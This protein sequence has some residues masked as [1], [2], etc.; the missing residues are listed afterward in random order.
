[1]SQGL[2]RYRRRD[3]AHMWKRGYEI[4]F[5]REALCRLSLPWT[6]AGRYRPRGRKGTRRLAVRRAEGSTRLRH[7]STGTGSTRTRESRVRDDHRGHHALRG[8][9]GDGRPS[10]PHW[11]RETIEVKVNAAR[12]SPGD[13]AKPGC[14]KPSGR[15]AAPRRG[16]SGDAGVR[17]RRRRFRA[18]PG[19]QGDPGTYPEAR[20]IA[21]TSRRAH[22]DWCGVTRWVPLWALSICPAGRL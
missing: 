17:T 9:R 3:G 18:R 14:W 20:Q 16:T 21:V 7:G 8:D 13:P 15:R 11:Q 2:L 4:P 19:A 1:M 22:A 10:D 5:A 6:A 12:A